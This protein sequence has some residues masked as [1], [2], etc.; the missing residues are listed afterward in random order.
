[1]STIN[2]LFANSKKLSTFKI[3]HSLKILVPTLLGTIVE[4]YDYVSGCQ[5]S[6]IDKKEKAIMQLTPRIRHGKLIS[7]LLS[8]LDTLSSSFNFNVLHVIP[9]HP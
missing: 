2:I 4:Y 8:R 9:S 3:F 5:V 6:T 7:C 1:M